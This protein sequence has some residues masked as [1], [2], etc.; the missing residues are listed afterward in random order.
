[1]QQN[2]IR[3]IKLARGGSLGNYAAFAGNGKAVALSATPP[4]TALVTDRCADLLLAL[5]VAVAG[6]CIN[7]APAPV[8][9]SA[10]VDLNV[11]LHVGEALSLGLVQSRSRA[12]QE[13]Q[14]GFRVA[15]DF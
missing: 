10:M 7:P 13:Q 4:R 15:E 11:L 8:T 9:A 6:V 3:S 14:G 5:G 2:V 1:M 12:P